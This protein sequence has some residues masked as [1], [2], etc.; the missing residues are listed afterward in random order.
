[1]S[2]INPSHSFRNSFPLESGS[3]LVTLYGMISASIS[4]FYDESPGKSKTGSCYELITKLGHKKLEKNTARNKKCAMM[5][6]VRCDQEHP[7]IVPY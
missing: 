1:M 7:C 2:S 6:G 3:L 4:I 5:E